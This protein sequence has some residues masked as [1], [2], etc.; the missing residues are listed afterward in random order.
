MNDSNLEICSPIFKV[1]A[2]ALLDVTIPLIDFRIMVPWTDLEL[3]SPFCILANKVFDILMAL[4]DKWA[5]E[6]YEETE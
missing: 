5:R 2:G 1:K 4:G 6:Y 3:W